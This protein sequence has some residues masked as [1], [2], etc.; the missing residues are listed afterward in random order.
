M[1]VFDNI[2][3]VLKDAYRRLDP[4]G[5]SALERRTAIGEEIMA[6]A[7]GGSTPHEEDRETAASDAISDVLTAM[8]GPAG[9]YVIVSEE[10]YSSER[11]DNVEA[12]SNAQGLLSHSMRSYEGDAEDYTVEPE[13]AL[14]EAER[15]YADGVRHGGE[16]T[17][18]TL[19]QVF[20][21]DRE[22]I[23]RTLIDLGVKNTRARVFG[24]ELAEESPVDFL[25]DI[26]GRFQRAVAAGR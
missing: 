1:R 18:A 11:V 16:I 13:P 19:R 21:E 24:P 15:T 25:L 6:V 10:P 26:F 4:D 5:H 22:L 12:L 3:D 9:H 23:D 17:L 7:Y 2:G 8:Y 14:H 20:A